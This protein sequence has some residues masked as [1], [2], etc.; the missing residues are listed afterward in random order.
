MNAE[1]NWWLLIVGLVIGAAVVYLVLADSSRRDA[2]VS[3]RE[4]PLEA[5]WIAATLRSEGIPAEPQTIERALELHAVYLAA[6]PPDNV[7]EV[8][9][10]R[11]KRAEARPEAGRTGAEASDE[12]VAV[13]EAGG[14]EPSVRRDPSD[15]E[16]D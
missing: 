14:P 16:R 3:A 8:D 12:D 11:P 13:A 7:E 10:A 4:R 1:F 6:P 9:A 2:D 15:V 5:T